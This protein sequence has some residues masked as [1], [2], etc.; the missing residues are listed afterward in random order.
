MSSY[1]LIR[2]RSADTLYRRSE[3][4]LRPQR[5]GFTLVLDDASFEAASY[6][7]TASGKITSVVSTPIHESL[8]AIGW[9]FF[10]LVA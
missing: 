1:I 2:L 6:G 5:L 4:S 9:Q 3:L 7:A 10:Q 8:S